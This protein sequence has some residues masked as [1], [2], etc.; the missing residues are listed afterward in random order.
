MSQE[1]LLAHVLAVQEEL[2]GKVRRPLRMH[3]APA[4]AL[5][6]GDAPSCVVCLHRCQ[7]HGRRARRVV[8]MADVAACCCFLLARSD[9]LP[10]CCLLLLCS[11]SC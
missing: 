7:H 5:A 1:A 4:T 11:G 10:F 2:C 8:G 3:A 6:S 9:S